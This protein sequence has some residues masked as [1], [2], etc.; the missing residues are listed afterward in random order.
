MK[1]LHSP[2]NASTP[3]VLTASIVASIVFRR[4]LI[5]NV[6]RTGGGGQFDALLSLDGRCKRAGWMQ[7]NLDQRQSREIYLQNLNIYVSLQIFRFHFFF[8]FSFHREKSWKKQEISKRF[9]FDRDRIIDR[10]FPVE[11]QKDYHAR[12][13]HHHYPRTTTTTV[14]ST[15]KSPSVSTT[16]VT[17]VVEQ[18]EDNQIPEVTR[19]TTTEPTE[20]WEI[21]TTSSTTI[22]T[23]P[24]T[25]TTTTTP[26][27]KYTH[28]FP[29]H[30]YI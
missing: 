23:T 16:T 12:R 28:A 5:R 13:K 24:T 29:T 6:G 27:R 4:S 17:T 25:T 19:W 14:L 11:S 2:E 18:V 22:S 3:R 15:T 30:T 8:F 20:T 9:Q 26:P 7:I 21:T 1:K 10:W